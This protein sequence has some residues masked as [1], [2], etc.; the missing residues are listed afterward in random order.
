MHHER[1]QDGTK[2]LSRA[3]STEEGFDKGPYVI[4]SFDGSIGREYIFQ[5]SRGN[6]SIYKGLNDRITEKMNMLADFLESNPHPLAQPA[7]ENDPL[8]KVKLRQ[9][10]PL[11]IPVF[12]VISASLKKMKFISKF[13]ES[14]G[15]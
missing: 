14:E 7:S 6:G 15:V 11:G 3:T 1:I 12:R 2:F 10:Y 8:W 9:Q 5:I 4:N 13:D